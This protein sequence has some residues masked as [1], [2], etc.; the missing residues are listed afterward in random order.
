MRNELIC[1]NDLLI[2]ST[3]NGLFWEKNVYTSLPKHVEEHRLTVC[4]KT[5]NYKSYSSMAH[6]IGIYLIY[7]I[8]KLMFNTIKLWGTSMKCIVCYRYKCNEK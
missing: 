7:N 8:N 2:N 5:K 3:E 4:C 1:S 6:P